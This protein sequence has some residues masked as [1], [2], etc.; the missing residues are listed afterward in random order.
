MRAQLPVPN[1]AGERPIAAVE[2]E[3]DDLSRHTG[4][5]EPAGAGRT[6]PALKAKLLAS[7]DITT[8]WDEADDRERRVLTEDLRCPALSG[9]PPMR[10]GGGT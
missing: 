6:G 10:V 2:P 5:S 4:P 7:V 8:V 3:T 1:L 9:L